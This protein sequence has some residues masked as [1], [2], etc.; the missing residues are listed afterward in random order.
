M[1]KKIIIIL[2]ISVVLISCGKKSCPKN[3]TEDKCNELFK[4]S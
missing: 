1:I 4:Q 3:N 2:F